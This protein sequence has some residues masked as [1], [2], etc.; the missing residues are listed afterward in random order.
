M[1]EE[2]VLLAWDDMTWETVGEVHQLNIS[3]DKFCRT[4]EESSL[5]LFPGDSEGVFQQSLFIWVRLSICWLQKR[6]ISI[7]IKFL[8]K[9]EILLSRLLHWDGRVYADLSQV[10]RSEGASPRD[11]RGS[12]HFKWSAK[13]TDCRLRRGLLSTISRAGSLDVSD[14]Q[15]V[16][17]L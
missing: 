15:V 14:L 9:C 5:T 8:V 3:L 4:S 1:D 17:V 6:N 13:R 11:L 2:K 7:L 12:P 10:T 16:D